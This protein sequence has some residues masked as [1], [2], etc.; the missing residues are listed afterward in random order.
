[1]DKERI[2]PFPSW[3]WL[4]GVVVAWGIFLIGIL[5]LLTHLLD[6]GVGP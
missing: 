5:T 3:G 6:P 2:G 1:M 4:Y